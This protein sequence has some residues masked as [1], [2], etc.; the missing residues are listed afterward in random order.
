MM[1]YDDAWIPP[2]R[3]TQQARCKLGACTQDGV[4]GTL[5][6]ACTLNEDGWCAACSMTADTTHQELR[7]DT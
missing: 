3:T 1:R 6:M 5:V 2:W 7:L 4:P